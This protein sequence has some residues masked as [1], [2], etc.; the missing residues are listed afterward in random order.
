[1]NID[2][3]Q[4]ELRKTEYVLQIRDHGVLSGL[5]IENYLLDSFQRPISILILHVRRKY[6]FNSL[7]LFTYQF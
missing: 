2:L 3:N 4:G 1:M 7:D 6:H 5:F